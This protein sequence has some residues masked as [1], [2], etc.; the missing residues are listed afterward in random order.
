MLSTSRKVD[1]RLPGKGNSNSHGARPVHLIITMIKWIRTTRLSIL[2]RRWIPGWNWSLLR[3]ISPRQTP[4]S[5]TTTSRHEPTLCLYI[6]LFIYLYIYICVYI[7]IYIY[8][9][10]SFHFAEADSGEPNYNLQARP[11]VIREPWM[12]RR[13]RGVSDKGPRMFG[14]PD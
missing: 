3:S 1:I 6:F 7:Y 5:P 10:P 4:A 2:S 14:M 13:D 12:S 9:Y 8:I 11:R